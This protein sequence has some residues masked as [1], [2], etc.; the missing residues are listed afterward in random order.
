MIV[1][2]KYFYTVSLFVLMACGRQ[3]VSGVSAS[4]LSGNTNIGGSIDL[5]VSTGARGYCVFCKGQGCN[6]EGLL[7]DKGALSEGQLEEAFSFMSDHEQ[8]ATAGI[9]FLTLLYAISNNG[10]SR[11]LVEKVIE[12]S[13]ANGDETLGAA[14]KLLKGSSDEF[15]GITVGISKNVK[16][17]ISWKWALVISA[18]GGSVIYRLAKGII[19]GEGADATVLQAALSVFPLNFLVEWR[20]RDDRVRALIDGKE[21]GFTPRKMS[22]IVSK[23]RDIRPEYP[24]SCNNIDQNSAS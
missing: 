18:S 5:S 19:E 6:G 3:P 1:F 11:K 9:P 2:I 12:A 23:L 14:G 20:Q 22:K 21:A 8:W 16:I 15:L 17:P 4:G 7:T 13:K 10:I 24:G